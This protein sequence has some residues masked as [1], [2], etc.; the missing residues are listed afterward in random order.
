[1]G[2]QG[3]LWFSM[4]GVEEFCYTRG[5]QAG[6]D[7]QY[8]ADDEVESQGISAFGKKGLVLPGDGLPR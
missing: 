5:F 4:L 3:F 2:A 6:Q 1:L 8:P 7:G